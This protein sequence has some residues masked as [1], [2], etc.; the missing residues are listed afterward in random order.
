MESQ[1]FMIIYD[2]HQ[3]LEFPLLLFDLKYQDSEAQLY[4]HYQ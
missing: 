1:T 2:F 3:H 4:Q